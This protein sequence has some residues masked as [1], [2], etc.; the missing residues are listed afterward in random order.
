MQND[1]VCLLGFSETVSPNLAATRSLELV[2]QT[3]KPGSLWKLV[4]VLPPLSA[5]WH[6]GNDNLLGTLSYGEPDNL[7]T[8]W[9]VPWTNPPQEF[10]FATRDYHD[11]GT[12]VFTFHLDRFRFWIHTLAASVFSRGLSATGEG[13]AKDSPVLS[14]SANA[15]PHTLQ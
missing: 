5:R 7:V 10:L 1:C 3:L 6:P 11:S 13:L 8:P 2:A 12:G 4:R 14:T 9:S 15:S